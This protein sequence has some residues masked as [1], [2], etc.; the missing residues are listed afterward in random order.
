[1][2]IVKTCPACGLESDE[3]RCPRCNALKLKGCTGVCSS[4]GSSCSS[5]PV[6]SPPACK[7]SDEAADDTEHCG[8]PLMR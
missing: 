3:I 7:P 4:C 6:P 8:T 1:M 5:G 2:T